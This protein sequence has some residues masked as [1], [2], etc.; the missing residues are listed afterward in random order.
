MRIG[1]VIEDGEKQIGFYPTSI[2]RSPIS[3]TSLTIS[4]DFIGGTVTINDGDSVVTR[5]IKSLLK[6]PVLINSRMVS[7]T[8]AKI[9][10]IETFH[11]LQS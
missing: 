5:P 3:D 10:A 7:G 4:R 9:K 6:K 8:L 2:P 1:L 11:G